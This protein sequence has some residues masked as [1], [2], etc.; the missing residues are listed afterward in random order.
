MTGGSQHQP[1]N[2]S[3][4]KRQ[5]ALHVTLSGVGRYCDKIMVLD[6]RDLLPPGSDSQCDY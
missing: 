6:D 3:F 4:P 1:L 5:L 2:V